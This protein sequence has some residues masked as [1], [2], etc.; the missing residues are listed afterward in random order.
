[1][2]FDTSIVID[3]LRRRR[4]YQY[5][6]ISTITVLEV[7]RGVA[8]SEMIETLLLMKQS[9]RVYDLD[10]DVI[11]SYSKLYRTLKERKT[12][13]KDADLIIGSTALAKNEK[14]L[15]KDRDF[16]TLNDFINVIEE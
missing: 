3:M 2:L 1:M 14:L 8:E 7:V 4:P 13:I 6:T 12:K 9:F 5:G 11:L 16:D 10:D 15:A